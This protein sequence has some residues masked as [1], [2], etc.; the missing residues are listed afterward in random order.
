MGIVL[1]IALL[2]ILLGVVSFYWIKERR[3]L[4][5]KTSE[6]MSERLWKEVIGEREE[7]L[8]KRRRFHDTLEKAKKGEEK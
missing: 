8:K 7:A 2:I 5:R 3:Y 1:T 4:K 6:V